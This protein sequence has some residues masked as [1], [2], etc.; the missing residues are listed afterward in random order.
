LPYGASPAS[1]SIRQAQEKLR[2]TGGRQA[3]LGETNRM[4]AMVSGFIDMID[5][6][7]GSDEMFELC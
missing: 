3:S 7:G 1:P 2:V 4:R 6:D 5:I